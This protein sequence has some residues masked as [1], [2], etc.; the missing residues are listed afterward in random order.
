MYDAAVKNQSSIPNGVS[1]KEKEKRY[2]LM[3]KSQ[4]HVKPCM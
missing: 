3:E 4:L 1:E 2:Q